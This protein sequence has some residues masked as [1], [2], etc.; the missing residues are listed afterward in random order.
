MSDNTFGK[1]FSFTTF[2]E[3]HGDALGTVIDGMP[4]GVQVDYDFLLSEMARRRPGQSLISTQRNEA[5]RPRI[6]SGV[7]EGKT[8][9]TPIAVIVENTDQRSNDYSDLAHTFRPGHADFTYTEKYGNRDYRGGGR[10]SGR[11]TLGRVIAGAFAKMALHQY[12]IKVDAAVVGVGEVSCSDYQW[13]PPFLPPLY[14]PE[15]K[16]KEKMIAL[17]EEARRDGDSIGST[18]ECVIQGVPAG[19]GSPVFDK[20]D[21]VLAHGIV[22]L[23]AVKGFEIGSG[24]MAAKGRGSQNNDEIEIV[25]GKPHF[26]TNNAGGILGGISNSDTIVFRSYFKPTPSISLPQKTI[27]D[28]KE[29]TVLVVKGRHDPIIGPRAVVV[30]EAMSAAIILDFLLRKRCDRI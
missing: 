6:L 9:G 3:S 7:F 15:C 21:A 27:T 11:E 20:L 30:V 26:L 5:D 13:N 10:S 8:T 25:D 4:S 24:F 28:E 2:G 23:G 17:I 22:S 1:I 19:L 16:E 29:D 18:V 12:G 14:A